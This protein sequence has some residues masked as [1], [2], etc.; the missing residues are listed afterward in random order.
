MTKPHRVH[1]SDFDSRFSKLASPIQKERD[2]TTLVPRI[3]A[4]PW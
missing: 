2:M 1:G 3:G 4:S